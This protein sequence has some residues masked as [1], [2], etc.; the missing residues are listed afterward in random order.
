MI[1]FVLFSN[2]LSSLCQAYDPKCPGKGVDFCVCFGGDGTL[3]HLNSVFNDDEIPPV[4]SF[5]LGSLGFL[6]P[7]EFKCV[8][9][10]SSTLPAAVAVNN[11]P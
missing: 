1:V 4:A 11:P 10:M 7:F 9:V 8:P 3:L 5:S 2:K 6:S